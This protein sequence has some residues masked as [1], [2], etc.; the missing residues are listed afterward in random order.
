MSSKGEIL[1]KFSLRRWILAIIILCTS[2][3]WA[4]ADALAQEADP[5]ALKMTA[6]STLWSFEWPGSNN[7]PYLVIGMADRGETP[8][9]GSLRI[10]G[11][12]AMNPPAST[13]SR[14]VGPVASVNR[15]GKGD[16][17][18]L[19]LS[20]LFEPTAGV[21]GPGDFHPEG[22]I[23]RQT[24]QGSSDQPGPKVYSLLD[25]GPALRSLLYGYQA[26][27]LPPKQRLANNEF[28][29][30]EVVQAPRPLFEIEFGS[31]R[32]PV[33]LS[34]PAVSK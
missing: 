25:D 34:G 19:V 15:A 27:Y 3:S 31:W 7:A 6:H 14:P 5:A 32:L 11:D 20:S 8:S 24:I 23:R 28:F 17:R 26:N 16:S 9:Y 30:H 1:R 29:T 12:G 13:I 33:M 10:A 4:S 2:A 18:P 22:T 21:R